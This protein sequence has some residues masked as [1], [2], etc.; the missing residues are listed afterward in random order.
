MVTLS[1]RKL[2]NALKFGTAGEVDSKEGFQFSERENFAP[3][4]CSEVGTPQGEIN[5]TIGEVIIRQPL[6]QRPQM[7][8]NFD[9][10]FYQKQFSMTHFWTEGAADPV[11]LFADIEYITVGCV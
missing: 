7:K 3:H 10:V 6:P 5:G 9:I 2:R 11:E 8:L 4:N 1:K